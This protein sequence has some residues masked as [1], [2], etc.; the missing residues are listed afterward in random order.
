[1]AT[2]LVDGVW[3][4]A[5]SGVNVYLRARDEV[6]LVDAGT[7]LDAGTIRRG[8]DDAG[9]G[10]GDVDRVLVTHFDLD[11]VGALWRLDDELDAPVHVSE[12]DRSYL[13]RAAAPPWSRKGAMQRVLRPFARPPDLSVEAVEDGDVLAG[14][15]AHHTPG[16]T[17]GHTVYGDEEAA[18]LGDLVF[19]DG[20]T[21]DASPWYVNYDTATVEDSI[22]RL[23]G[24]DPAFDV[25][26]Q[27]HG[28]PLP[29]GGSEALVTLA[30][31]LG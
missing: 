18:F 8:I 17:P 23:A 31:R 14:L 24:T 16:H 20:E 30:G 27:G 2:E 25:G 28:E 1:M 13:T 4:I 6:V 22:R 10:L 5:C 12:P 19:G 9:H 15:T 26:C 29:T 21:Y 11:H 7:P 3:R